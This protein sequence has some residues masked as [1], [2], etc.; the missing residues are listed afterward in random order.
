MGRFDGYLLCSDFDG[1][2]AG[3]GG[4]VSARNLEAIEYY[5]SEGGL[6][7]LASG[8][9]PRF[10]KTYCDITHP[11]AP[12]ISLNGGIIADA[13]SC[14]TLDFITFPESPLSMLE[15]L[16]CRFPQL[17]TI[18]A[19]RPNGDIVI[20]QRQSGLSPFEAPGGKEAV[21]SHALT[22]QDASVMPAVLSDAK[23]KYAGRYRFESSWPEGIEITP[24]F[25]GKGAALQRLRALIGPSV[26]VTVG[27]GD[28]ENDISLL[29]QADIGIAVSN[30]LNEV[31]KAAD[32]VTVSNCEDA[33]WHVVNLLL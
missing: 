9:N 5:K 6:F 30:A 29:K 23:H 24:V 10:L 11:N 3:A 15:D 27:M 26:R 33:L 32:I 12:V 21:F 25:G 8:R 14:E 22:I 4:L 17:H 16:A 18:H 20:W 13:R 28:Y 1:T 19:W 7:T 2:L 31:K